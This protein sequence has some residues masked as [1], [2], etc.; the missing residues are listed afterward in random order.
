MKTFLIRARNIF[1]AMTLLLSLVAHADAAGGND[2][3]KNMRGKSV[4][5]S[6]VL[7][8]SEKPTFKILPSS[9]VSE[10]VYFSTNGDIFFL[11]KG[12][13]AKIPAGG[14]SASFTDGGNNGTKHIHTISYSKR[15]DSIIINIESQD[16]SKLFFKRVLTIS[17]NSCKFSS[18]SKYIRGHQRGLN[19]VIHSRQCRIVSGR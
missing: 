10:S 3:L 6:Y 5:I 12:G 1:V 16:P 7:E 18:S 8:A 2:A 4:K 13:G 15:R 14:K 17:E 11:R 19:L 9:P